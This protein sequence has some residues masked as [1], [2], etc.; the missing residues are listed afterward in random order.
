MA[1]D[2]RTPR[3]RIPYSL[4]YRA[5]DA[6]QRLA[7]EKEEKMKLKKCALCLSKVHHP[8]EHSQRVELN[9]LK[10]GMVVF[11]RAIVTDVEIGNCTSRVAVKS[12]QKYGGHVWEAHSVNS[13]DIFPTPLPP[14]PRRRPR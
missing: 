2:E 7:G 11:V 10:L 8:T 12:Y 1:G 9:R 5:G 13:V 4:D 6:R 14:G 3:G